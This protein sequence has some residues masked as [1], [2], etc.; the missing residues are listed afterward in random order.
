MIS[1]Y[2]HQLTPIVLSLLT[3]GCLGFS[4]PVL[5]DQTPVTLPPPLPISTGTLEDLQGIPSQDASAWLG[6]VGGAD[7]SINIPET[8]PYQIQT[9][10]D[11]SK[12]QDINSTL[13]NGN[14]KLGFTQSM[15]FAH[16]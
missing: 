14:N 7:E 13:N 9:T 12:T 2:S 1:D 10:P 3:L 15:P 4:L 16:F 11:N 6:N 8:L 5:A